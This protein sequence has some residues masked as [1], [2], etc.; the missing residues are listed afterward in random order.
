LSAS[1]D[2]GPA[3]PH[4]PDHAEGMSLRDWFA[5][6]ALAG[7]CK[8]TDVGAAETCGDISKACYQLADAML[9]EREMV[10]P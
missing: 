5:G 10:R 6:V 8:P 3:F 1:N 4:G 2:G 7:G 9:A